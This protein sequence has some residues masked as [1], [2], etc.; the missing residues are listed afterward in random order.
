M[1]SSANL[2]HGKMS[3]KQV[4]TIQKNLAKEGYINDG[5]KSKRAMASKSNV[6]SQLEEEKKSNAAGTVQHIMMQSKGSG[7]SMTQEKDFNDGDDLEHIKM[8]LQR[9]YVLNEKTGRFNL[10]MTCLICK[11]T[12]PALSTAVRH[13]RTHAQSR[14]FQCEKCGK[15]FT[16]EGNRNL[17]RDTGVCDRRLKSKSGQM[18]AYI[19]V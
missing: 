3:R 19:Q 13:T 5:H 1:H 14:P 16:Q 11:S 4:N 7:R 18:K 12:F 8:S 15:R 9:S 17:H 6:S 10:C 2:L